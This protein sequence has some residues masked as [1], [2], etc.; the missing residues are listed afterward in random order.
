MHMPAGA[1]RGAQG[2]A[3]RALAV[4]DGLAAPSLW[5]G[6]R[7]C[8]AGRSMAR[9]A[10][11][12]ENEPV[13]TVPWRTWHPWFGDSRSPGTGGHAR[14][15]ERAGGCDAT[16]PRERGPYRASR[17]SRL[18]LHSLSR[19]RPARRQFP[20]ATRRL[21]ACDPKVGTRRI[22]ILHNVG[23]LPGLGTGRSSHPGS[24]SEQGSARRSDEA[25]GPRSS[26]PTAT[27]IRGSV[28]RKIPGSGTEV[29]PRSKSLPRGRRSLRNQRCL[30]FPTHERVRMSFYWIAGLIVIALW[31]L[32]AIVFLV[33]DRRSPRSEA[34]ARRSQQETVDERVQG[35]WPSVPERA[36]S[37]G[38]R[39]QPPLTTRTARHTLLNVDAREPDL[40]STEAGRLIA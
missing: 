15:S 34:P 35:G 5:N 23:A 38:P 11:T 39:G 1:L 17:G 37:N 22:P 6:P 2:E 21:Y 36:R 27:A 29:C 4:P 19:W 13:T 12:P 9:R 32:Q 14:S 31:I 30:P 3:H 25:G 8:G 24:A 18:A 28:P 40:H 33:G 20:A 16:G 7:L 26:K 10:V